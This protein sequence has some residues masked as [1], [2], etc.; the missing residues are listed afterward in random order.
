M[1][2]SRRCMG[3]AARHLALGDAHRT[4][5]AAPFPAGLAIE[6]LDRRIQQL[7]A[8]PEGRQP[9]AA[10]WL[11]MPRTFALHGVDPHFFY[12]S[13]LW[14]VDPQFFGPP[15]SE[16]NGRLQR[17]DHRGVHVIGFLTDLS[18]SRSAPRPQTML[19]VLTQTPPSVSGNVLS[20]TAPPAGH[21]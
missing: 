16:P 20:W 18:G 21:Y 11:M 9:Q 3:L 7:G 4:S 2:R 19:T 5:A 6:F 14:G 15:R 1:R 10:P 8:D 13:A 17:A 12:P